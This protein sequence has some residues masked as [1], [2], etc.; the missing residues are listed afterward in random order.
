MRIVKQRGGRYNH[1]T[2]NFLSEI[3]IKITV[4]YKELFS[5]LEGTT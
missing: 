2:D 3:M 1:M 4:D 5:R